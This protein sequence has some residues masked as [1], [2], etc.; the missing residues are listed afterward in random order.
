LQEN[1]VFEAIWDRSRLLFT[2][3][4]RSKL[5]QAVVALNGLGGI[6]GIVANELVRSG[7]GHL[8]LSDPDVFEPTNFGRQLYATTKTL[9]RNK[10][11]VTKERMLEINPYCIVE[12]YTEG[13]QKNNVF[14]VL[15]GV[16]V[17]IDEVD[18]WSRSLIQHRA[19]K[20]MGIPLVHGARAGF[21]DGRWTIQ[22]KVWN[23]RDAPETK[24]REE[25][26]KLWTCNLTWDELTEDV[27]NKVDQEITTSMRYKIREE[28]VKGNSATFGRVSG[29][30]LLSQ[31]DGDREEPFKDGLL[32]KRAIFVQIP[33]TV[34]ILASLEAIK[35]ILGWKTSSYKMNLLDG[36]LE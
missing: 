9:G 4:D 36:R 23:Y 19:A 12:V 22:V 26:N 31:L 13:V 17:L 33:N 34:G 3:E 7:I 25:T 14:E 21:P 16:D 28:I 24:T 6:G 1:E 30:Y 18:I 29:E 32:H 5:R 2:D 20:E 27:L 35:L 8:K 10:A 11:E 15:E